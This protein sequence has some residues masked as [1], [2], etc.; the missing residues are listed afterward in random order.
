MQIPSAPNTEHKC[1]HRSSSFSH[2]AACPLAA[3]MEEIQ[4]LETS[5]EDIFFYICK[6][7]PV[8]M[9]MRRGGGWSEMERED[10]TRGLLCQ[11]CASHQVYPT[12]L[13]LLPDFPAVFFHIFH[14]YIFVTSVPKPNRQC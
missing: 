1:H 3:N 11:W 7:A 4:I 6:T 14:W 13:Y 2:L 9:I 5:F 10:W 12:Y 8:K